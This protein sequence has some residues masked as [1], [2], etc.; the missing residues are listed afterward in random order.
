M[1]ESFSSLLLDFVPDLLIDASDSKNNTGV[2]GIFNKCVSCIV[3]IKDL[4]YVNERGLAQMSISGDTFC[5][6]SW[7]GF[8][9]NLKHSEEYYFAI[10]AGEFIIDSYSISIIYMNIIL[11][12]VIKTIMP[13]DEG[14]YA[15][16]WYYKTY[17]QRYLEGQNTTYAIAFIIFVSSLI[18]K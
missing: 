2:K 11:Y 14:V 12:N 13:G 18:S 10:N 16:N 9:L 4:Y 1:L 8:M 6:S 3:C 17:V 15:T 7:V 5:E